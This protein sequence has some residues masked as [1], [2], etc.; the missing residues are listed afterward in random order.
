MHSVSLAGTSKI[1]VT[2][3][4]DA[5]LPQTPR[6]QRILAHHVGLAHNIQTIQLTVVVVNSSFSGHII[7]KLYTFLQ[8][9]SNFVLYKNSCL[10]VAWL[11]TQDMSLR[12]RLVPCF[13]PLSVSRISRGY[14]PCKSFIAALLKFMSRQNPW[15]SRQ[16][17]N[18]DSVHPQW[19]KT[20]HVYPI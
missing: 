4:C 17:A 10:W 8:T 6:W 20:L 9:K 14:V 1:S 2:M 7:N 13:W 3:L 15:G 19:S 11:F 16:S 5:T 12:L 18:P